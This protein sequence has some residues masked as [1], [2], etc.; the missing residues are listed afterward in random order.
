MQVEI[1]KFIQG[2]KTPLLDKLFELITITAE[3]TTIMVIVA[4]VFWCISKDLGYRMGFIF[5]SGN[6]LNLCLKETFHTA[7]PIGVEGIESLRTHTAHGYSFPSGHTQTSTMFWTTLMLYC[8]NKLLYIISILFFILVGFS[9]MY[10][11]VHWPIDVAG[12]IVIGFIWV[13]IVNKIYDYTTKTK[14]GMIFLILLVPMFIGLIFFKTDSYYKACAAMLGLYI[15]YLIEN[16][17]IQY[18]TEAGLITQIIKAVL[19]LVILL[20]LKE[21]IKVVLPE[22]LISDFLRYT[23]IGI[24]ITAGATYVFSKLFGNKSSIEKEPTYKA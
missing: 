20:G 18:E 21:G 14:N 15:G 17:Y 13:I 4:L 11:G 6:A 5:L 8:K 10:L 22:T 24:W 7:R 23:I 9:R 2:F 19:G 16:R 1:L 3:E 12:G